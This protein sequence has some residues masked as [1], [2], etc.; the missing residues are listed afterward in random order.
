LK[1]RIITGKAGWWCLRSST[2]WTAAIAVVWR[3]GIAR[4]STKQYLSLGVRNFWNKKQRNH[5]TLDGK[6]TSA[7]QTEKRGALR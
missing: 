4:T 2:T 5:L 1:E 6:K 7:W 3:A